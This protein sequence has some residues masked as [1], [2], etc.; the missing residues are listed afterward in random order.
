[1]TEI[2]KQTTLF[3][4]AEQVTGIFDGIVLASKRLELDPND[5]EA[6][7]AL[8][9]YNAKLR[10]NPNLHIAFQKYKKETL[11]KMKGLIEKMETLGEETL[12]Q[13]EKAFLQNMVSKVG[14]KLPL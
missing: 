14:D 7:L 11:G 5:T 1:M 4:R 10:S 12:T 2:K 3:G 9:I 8:N 13:N 6:N